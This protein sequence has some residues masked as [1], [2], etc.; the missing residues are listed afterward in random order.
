MRDMNVLEILGDGFVGLF[1]KM[2]LL[3]RCMRFGLE[4]TIKS[5][6]IV[7]CEKALL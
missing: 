4:L 7:I 6:P 1:Q 2:N 3:T 5:M